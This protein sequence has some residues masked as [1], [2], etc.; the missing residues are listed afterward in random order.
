MA[1]DS[2]P[3]Y[4]IGAAAAAVSLLSCAAA[5]ATPQLTFSFSDEW[6]V[7]TLTQFHTAFGASA[8]GFTTAGIYQETNTTTPIVTQLHANASTSYQLVPGEFVQNTTPN[9]NTALLLNGWSHNFSGAL[10]QKVNNGGAGVTSVNN[11][12]TG[13]TTNLNFQYLTGASVTP[14]TG[15]ISGTVSVFNFTSVDFNSNVFAIGLTAEGLRGGVVVDSMPMSINTSGLWKTYAFNWYNVDEIA[16]VGTSVQGSLSMRNVILNPEPM[17][18]ALFG[19]GLVGL[20]L[21]RRHRRR[22][23]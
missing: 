21:I 3:K 5:N 13:L 16:F 4:I 12:N 2:A 23:T 20:G 9:A 11:S 22:R 1:R 6:Y 8:T 14:S 18:L 15:V 19:T 17:S 7:S 10:P